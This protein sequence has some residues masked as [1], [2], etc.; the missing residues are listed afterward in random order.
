MY[1]GRSGG[2]KGEMVDRKRMIN[3]ALD[4]HLEKSSPSTSRADEKAKDKERISVPSTSSGKSQLKNNCS[5]G[6]KFFL[7]LLFSTPFSVIRCLD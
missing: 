6:L 7:F 2:G 5:D 3:D 1:G 4:K